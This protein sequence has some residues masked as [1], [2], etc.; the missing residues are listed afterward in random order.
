MFRSFI[1]DCFWFFSPV[2]SVHEASIAE[3]KLCT[4]L[5]RQNV[6]NETLSS[7]SNQDACNSLPP[8]FISFLRSLGRSFPPSLLPSLS[9]S[10]L[11][12]LSPSLPHSFPPSLY[13]SPSLPLSLSLPPPSL[14]LTPSLS[15]SLPLS[16]LLLLARLLSTF[17]SSR[18]NTLMHLLRSW[19][20]SGQSS[21]ANHVD[22]AVLILAPEEI[23]EY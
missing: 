22:N 5:K 6:P 11:P 15:P 20:Q 19:Q 12:S 21:R 18:Q 9:P 8:F 10:L 14:Y 23:Q 3:Q 2:V 1:I 17:Y 4:E 16:L 13:L 7:V